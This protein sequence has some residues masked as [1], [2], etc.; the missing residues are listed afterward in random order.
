M[1]Y[2]YYLVWC[3][4]Y[5]A[6]FE[7]ELFKKLRWMCKIDEIKKFYHSFRYMDDL[8][9]I[10]KKLILNCLNRNKFLGMIMTL[11]PYIN[12]IFYK[13]SPPLT[14]ITLHFST[15]RSLCLKTLGGEYCTSIAWKKDK[16]PFHTMHFI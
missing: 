2:S 14:L 10:N 9:F 16:L 11:R 6:W 8:A 13:L 5:L 1:G 4:L 12:L 7:L 3:N 15:L